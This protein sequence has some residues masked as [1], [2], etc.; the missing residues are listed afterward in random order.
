MPSRPELSKRSQQVLYALLED[1]I[2]EWYATQ[3]AASARLRSGTIHPALA[4][5]ERMRWVESRWEAVEEG[6][7]ARPA[8]RCYR[9]TTEGRQQAQAA[10]AAMSRGVQWRMRPVAGQS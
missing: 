8:R 10:L 1:P 3:I 5:L 6:P 9:L 2:A 7:A 4:R